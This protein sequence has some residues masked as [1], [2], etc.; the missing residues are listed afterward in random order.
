MCLVRFGYEIG[1]RLSIENIPPSPRYFA[2]GPYEGA[3]IRFGPP[4]IK[5]AAV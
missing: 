4:F 3:Q 2:H 1:C 5:M